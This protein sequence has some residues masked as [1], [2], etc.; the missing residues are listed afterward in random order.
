MLENC[1][2]HWIATAALLASATLWPPAPG[3]AAALDVGSLGVA[4]TIDGTIADGEWAGAV[5]ADQ[6][7]VQIEPA[8]GELSPVRTIV[9]V[10]QTAT[11]LYVAFEAFDPEIS[12]L[13]AAITQRDAITNKDSN[14]VQDD[15]VAV[16]LDPFGDE[17]TAY[18]FRTN[19]LATQE[20]GRISDNG[21]AVDVQWDGVWRSA[22]MR[23]ADRWTVE[24]EIPFSTLLYAAGAERAWKANFVRTVPRRLETAVWS[25]PSES[26]F[27]VS[28]FGELTGIETPRQSAD[29]WQFI[30]YAITSFEVGK[31]ARAEFGGDVRWRPS[32]NLGV[33]LTYNPDFALVDAD[34]EVINL[35]RFEVQVPERRPFF[36]E[37]T[38]MFNQRYRQF[39]SRRL[40][41]ISWGAKANGK[42]GGTDF[43][44]IAASEDL[45]FQNA[46]AEKTAYYG[47]VRAQQ[48]LWRGSNIGLLA[49]NRTLGGENTGSLGFD[50][51]MYFTDTLSFNGQFFRVHGPTADGGVAWYIRPSY[52]TS[53]TH[54]HVRI[55]HFAPGIRN[56]FNVMGFLQDDN[57]KD[58]DT[59]FSHIFFFDTGPIE[60]VRPVVNFNRYTSFDH[61]TLRGWALAPAVATVFRNGF[62]FEIARRD[63]YRLF[64]KG[65]QNEQTTFTGGW[66]SRDGRSISAYAGT[67]RNFGN[68]LLLYGGEAHY[69]IGDNWRVSYNLTRLELS[70]DLKRESTTIHVFETSYNFSPDL[71]VRGF[72]Q[73]NSAI[74]KQN[75]QLLGV[76][77]FNPPFG[78]LQVAYQRGTSAF[79][80][81]SSQGDT[82]FT[83]LA[84]VL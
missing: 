14:I 76:W 78:A 55:G 6:N 42:L 36:L 15:S 37:G 46:A 51:T 18:I 5:V 54:F 49:A 43:S 60:R 10:M 26:V 21:R 62:E 66:N 28:G 29:V 31:G 47:I 27:R 81:Q 67:G 24:F 53:T 9:R 57:R 11:G 70:P 74:D 56:D 12:R 4:P 58:F 48:G 72:V 65:Y 59:N 35:T 23:H 38:E 73:T 80:Q 75:I 20:D 22:A 1:W 84:W 8:Y 7:F 16:L 71:F 64:E 79:G 69:A 17:R 77:R 33:D 39:H 45:K 68:D 3:Y 30:P 50:T 61:S 52:D 44:V 41:D 2:R 32:S 40:G 25:G 63:E 82:I 19:A 34:V 83:K 13:G